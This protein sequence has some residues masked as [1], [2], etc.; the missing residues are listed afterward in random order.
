MTQETTEQKLQEITPETMQQLTDDFCLEII[1]MAQVIPEAFNE[2]AI[3][4]EVKERLLDHMQVAYAEGYK[5][6]IRDMKETRG[7]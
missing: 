6:G 5:Q 1:R 7:E 2:W 4:N 3:N